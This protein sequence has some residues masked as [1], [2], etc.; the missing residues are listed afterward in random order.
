MKDGG[1][2][3]DPGRV[4]DRSGLKLKDRKLNNHPPN[5]YNQSLTI[6]FIIHR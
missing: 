6:F 3:A 2:S 4:I 5:K 1:N